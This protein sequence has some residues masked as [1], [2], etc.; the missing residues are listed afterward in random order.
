V[1]PFAV[2]AA[3]VARGVLVSAVPAARAAD[4]TGPLLRVSTAPWLAPDDL[5]R[6]AGLLA[7][8][9]PLLDGAGG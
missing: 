6:V 3:L 2:R 4:L 8:P 7:Q 1:D 5:R 9:R